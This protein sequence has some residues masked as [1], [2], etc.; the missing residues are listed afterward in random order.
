[1]I[2]KKIS[3]SLSIGGD[4]DPGEGGA[5]KNLILGVLVSPS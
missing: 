5:V 4:P 3:I 2:N 1:M